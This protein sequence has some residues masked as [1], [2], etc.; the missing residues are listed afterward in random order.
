MNAT[1]DIDYSFDNATCN[2]FICAIKYANKAVELSSDI[3]LI[4]KFLDNGQYV[5]I[6]TN[7][8]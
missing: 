2:N 6:V 3:I 1:I 4:K 5:K 8:Q 7:V